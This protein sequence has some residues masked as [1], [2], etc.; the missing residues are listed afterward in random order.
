MEISATDADDNENTYNAAIGYS[1]LSQEP[2][3][4]Q[5]NMF[6]VDNSS[7]IIRVIT[8]GLDR[9]V[10]GQGHPAGVGQIDL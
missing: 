8:P 9:E 7:G 4:P 10:R 6:S 2:P 3:L 1:I 5:P